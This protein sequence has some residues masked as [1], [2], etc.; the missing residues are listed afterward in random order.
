MTTNTESE[1][2]LVDDPFVKGEKCK[3]WESKVWPGLR[4][5]ESVARHYEAAESKSKGDAA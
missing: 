3:R 5:A 2:D 4:L 1:S